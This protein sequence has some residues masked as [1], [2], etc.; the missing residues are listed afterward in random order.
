M[1]H[2]LDLG[3]SGEKLG[4]NFLLDGTPDGTHNIGDMSRGHSKSATQS[5]FNSPLNLSEFLFYLFRA[6]CNAS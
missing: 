1:R 4:L 5:S 6:L 3:A 2:G